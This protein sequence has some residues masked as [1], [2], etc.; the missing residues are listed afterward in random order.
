LVAERGQ[1]Y[2]QIGNGKK[3]KNTIFHLENEGES[4][5]RE[6]DIIKHATEYT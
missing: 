4:I 2:Y 6:E 1:Q 3:R 5:N